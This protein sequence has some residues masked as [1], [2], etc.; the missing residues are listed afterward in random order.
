M[1]V[2][3][4]FEISDLKFVL[5]PSIHI[6]EFCS[7]IGKD[8]E[9]AVISFLVN[10]KRAALDVIGF[11]ENG[12][13]FILDADISASEIKPGSYLVY[14][15]I[16]R[17]RRLIT[18]IFQLISDLSAAS[19]LKQNEWKFKYMDDEYHPLSEKNLKLFV[20]LSPRN[21]REQINRPIDNLKQAAGIKTESYVSTDPLIQTLMHAAGIPYDIKKHI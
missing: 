13:D 7:K 14:V 6:D 18:Q 8:D 16:L 9:I 20:P 12:Y 3:E 11:F 2:L 17:R 5:E 10:D 21:Y 1:K 4:S 19:Q 15:E